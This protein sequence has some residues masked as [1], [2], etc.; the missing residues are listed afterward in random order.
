MSYEYK[1]I[2]VPPNIT[3]KAKEEKGNEAAVYLQDLANAQATD[4]WEFY[5]VDSIGVLTQP[6]CLAAMMG[7]K[8]TLIHYFVV[9]FRRLVSN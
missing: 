4:G 5:R 9:T 1:M 3:V 7:A 6:G 8:Q 2:Q